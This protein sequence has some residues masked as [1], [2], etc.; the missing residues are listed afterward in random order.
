MLNARPPSK[1]N[2]V[3][4]ISLACTLAALEQRSNL[5]FEPKF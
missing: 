3:V 4:P 2:L 5:S 1:D